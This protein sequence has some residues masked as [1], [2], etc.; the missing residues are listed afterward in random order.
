VL[1]PKWRHAI[2]VGAVLA[3]AVAG[4]AWAGLGSGGSK[5]RD[6]VLNDVATRLGISSAKLKSAIQDSLAARVDAAVKDGRLTKEQA[7]EIKSH[8]RAGD[9]GIGLGPPGLGVRGF[10]PPGFHHAGPPPPIA[11]AAEFLGLTPRQ[12]FDQLRGG[13]SL[14]DLA[15]AKGKSSDDLEQAILDSARKQLDQAVKDKALTQA[16]E[17]QM[18]DHLGSDLPK[19][20]TRKWRREGGFGLRRAPGPGQRGG[21]APPPIP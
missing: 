1:V 5:D 16:Q 8:I 14:A 21:F 12:L 20:I 4:V 17:K 2:A 11:G 10:G 3:V 19:L 9:A 13:K 6:A 15:K 18:L 7:A